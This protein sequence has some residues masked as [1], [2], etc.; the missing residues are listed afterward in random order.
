MRDR[1][2]P[3][4]IFPALMLFALSEDSA[5]IGAN[6]PSEESKKSGHLSLL[7]DETSKRMV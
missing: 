7:S 2:L 4:G 6:Y 1:R 3:F 5:T